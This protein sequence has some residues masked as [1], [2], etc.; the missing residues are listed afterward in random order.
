MAYWFSVLIMGFF[1]L[2]LVITCIL[3]M[4]VLDF[5]FL[6]GRC[7]RWVGVTEGYSNS[8]HWGSIPTNE[9]EFSW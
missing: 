7:R 9:R 8:L 3:V 2:S 6:I 5:I 1:S 4:K